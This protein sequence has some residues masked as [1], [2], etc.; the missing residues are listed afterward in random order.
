ML[1]LC[2][3]ATY[4]SIGRQDCFPVFP[5]SSSK[6]ASFESVGISNRY[7][8]TSGIGGIYCLDSSSGSKVWNYSI[9]Y[10]LTSPAIA[11]DVLFAG[12]LGGNLALN[13]TTGEVI[14]KNT[15]NY[16]QLTCMDRLSSPTVGEGVIYEGG[17]T[18]TSHPKTMFTHQLY[19]FN[20]STGQM[21][22]KYS[23][24]RY[25][26]ST[27]YFAPTIANNML[28]IPSPDGTHVYAFGIVSQTVGEL[29]V[30]DLWIILISVIV[31]LVVA[32]TLLYFARHRKTTKQA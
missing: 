28:Y 1:F 20:A 26:D 31:L 11:D 32:V 21:M 18:Q 22:M 16:G 12:A 17:S 29:Q 2:S 19:A 14:W 24:P 5:A 10:G 23:F 30:G 7:V 4:S 25:Y 9:G 3:S 8:Y 6:D 15:D 27:N 13:A